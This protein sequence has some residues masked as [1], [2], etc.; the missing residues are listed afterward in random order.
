MR[1]AC[2]PMPFRIEFRPRARKNFLALDK[3]I[4]EPIGSAIDALAE[5]PRLSDVKSIVGV[6]GLL[7][8][9]IGAYRVLYRVID[10]ESLILIVDVGHR[11]DIYR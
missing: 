3:P 10:E 1:R 2:K 4:R 6:P 5:D 7:R 11:R 8:T 9:R